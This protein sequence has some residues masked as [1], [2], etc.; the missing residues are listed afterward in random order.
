MHN[1]NRIHDEEEDVETSLAISSLRNGK[2]LPDPCKDHLIHRGPI[3]DKETPIIVE[4]ESD[5]EDEEE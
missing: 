4:Q 3:E 1:I 2:D 5:L